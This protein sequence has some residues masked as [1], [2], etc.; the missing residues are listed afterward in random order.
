MSLE[1][2]EG[3][4]A[5]Y[6]WGDMTRDL[7]DKSLL[8]YSSKL[9]QST[10][11]AFGHIMARAHARMESMQKAWATQAEGPAGNLPIVNER[12]HASV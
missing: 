6:L 9:M 5:A 12:I 10:D 2:N 7:N 3:A 11:D 4:K 1:G 8:T